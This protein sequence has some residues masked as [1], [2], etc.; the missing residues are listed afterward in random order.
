[1]S[2]RSQQQQDADNVIQ[3]DISVLPEPADEASR[4]RFAVKIE[5]EDDCWLW[6]GGRGTRARRYGLFY[7]RGVMHY[8]HRWC[9]REFIGPIPAKHVIHHTCGNTLCVNLDHLQAVTRSEHG[10]IHWKLRCEQRA[11]A[12]TQLLALLRLASQRERFSHP[13]FALTERTAA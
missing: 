11:N 5:C 8:A 13:D 7:F 12:L 3:R 4:L 9:Y 10:K 2:V 1:M 6:K